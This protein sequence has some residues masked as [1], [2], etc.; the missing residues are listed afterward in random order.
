MSPS[1]PVAAAGWTTVR[2]ASAGGDL[3]PA[4]VAL[5]ALNKLLGEWR[6]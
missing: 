5:D 1:S 3:G 4:R 2:I 6:R